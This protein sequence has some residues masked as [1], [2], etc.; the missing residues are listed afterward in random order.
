MRLRCPV[1]TPASPRLPLPSCS[2]LSSPA[3]A[4]TL[5]LAAHSSAVLADTVFTVTSA[6]LHAG[7]TVDAAQVFDRDDCKG[8]N[9]SPQLSWHD[10]PTG[11]RSFAVTV[12]DPDAPGRGWWHW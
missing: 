4:V 3:A 11:T 5:A 7:G 12:Y 1:V 6:N 9:R 8:G 2:M 10:A